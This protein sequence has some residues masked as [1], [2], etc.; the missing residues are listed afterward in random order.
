MED[1][2]PHFETGLFPKLSPDELEHDPPQRI[3]SEWRILRG[4]Y[5]Y[6]YH[7]VSE[8]MA[9]RSESS[10]N[11]LDAISMS[12]Y[13]PTWEGMARKMNVKPQEVRRYLCLLLLFD[14]QKIVLTDYLKG[15]IEELIPERISV[16]RGNPYI[17]KIER[18]KTRTGE[19]KKESVWTLKSD[20]ENLLWS[21]VLHFLLPFILRSG[22]YFTMPSFERKDL[23]H[24]LEE[25]G[26]THLGM[27]RTLRQEQKQRPILQKFIQKFL[28]PLPPQRRKARSPKRRRSS[29]DRSGKSSL[30]HLGNKAYYTFP[31]KTHSIPIYNSQG[32]I[33]GYQ[34]SVKKPSEED[35]FK[36]ER[37][38]ISPKD[39]LIENYILDRV[40]QSSW[41]DESLILQAELDHRKEEKKWPKIK[42]GKLPDKALV[43][44]T[45][46]AFNLV[47]RIRPN[48]LPKDPMDQ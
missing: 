26:K 42:A 12:P 18:R 14:P 39:H 11:Q 43:A 3:R 38:W 23:L 46:R 37:I 13:S 10:Q 32:E 30:S 24:Y 1:H 48:S 17:N 35:P 21:R 6:T 40:R 27:I 36:P 7:R 47:N 20:A 29:E 34:D 45:R 15:R 4:S 8:Q 22:T 33:V 9:P 16:E 28:Q 31:G 5:D 2:S 25:Y 19:Y 41:R 44:R